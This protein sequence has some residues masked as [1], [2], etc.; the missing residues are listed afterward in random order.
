[1]MEIKQEIEYMGNENQ[2]YSEYSMYIHYAAVLRS[3]KMTFQKD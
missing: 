1:M 2:L 3:T